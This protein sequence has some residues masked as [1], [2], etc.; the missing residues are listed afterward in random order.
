M[1]ME[2]THNI[3]DFILKAAP[4]HR[5]DFTDI[6]KSYLVDWQEELQ[7]LD[8]SKE[9]KDYD[10]AKNRNPNYVAGFEEGVKW[11]RNKMLGV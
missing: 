10:F 6:V 7:Q 4:Y 2:E 9:I 5:C 11:L 8:I 3:M 1:G